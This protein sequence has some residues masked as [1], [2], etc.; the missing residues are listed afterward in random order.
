MLKTDISELKIGDWCFQ[1]TEAPD[2][3]TILD[4]YIAL[5][6]LE[7][8][9]GLVILPIYTQVN[10]TNA[11]GQSCWLWDG[12]KEAPTLSP[13]ILHWGDGKDKP[14]TWH[15]YLRKGQLVNA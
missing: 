4:A 14:A 8:D 9:R 2:G 1:N 5:R 7:L 15:G 11:H 13:S 10:H 3:T 12:N 6:F